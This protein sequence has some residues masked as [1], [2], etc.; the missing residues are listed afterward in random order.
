LS[1]RRGLFFWALRLV[2]FQCHAC[3]RDIVYRA[4]KKPPATC[5][6]CGAPTWP[7]FAA[8]A[9]RRAAEAFA[10]LTAA[11]RRMSIALET[12]G[13][14]LRRELDS[15]LAPM[16]RQPDDRLDALAWSLWHLRPVGQT[17]VDTDPNMS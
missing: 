3:K 6:W 9:L 1:P 2:S 14:Q 11:F 12:S 4:K 8:G 10:D 17:R 16:V 5:H 13:E 15:F 7:V